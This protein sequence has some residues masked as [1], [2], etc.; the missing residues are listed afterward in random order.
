MNKKLDGAFEIQ[1]SRH[2]RWRM[3]QRNISLQSIKVTIL[4]GRCLRSGSE[5]LY[6]LDHRW[7]RELL[8]QG[9]DLQLYEGIIVVVTSTDLVV[10]VYRNHTPRRVRQ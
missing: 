2:G 9:I 7:I 4:Y 5:L 8:A 1:I 10:T 6:R 3:A